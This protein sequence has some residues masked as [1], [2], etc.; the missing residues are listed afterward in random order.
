M[1][2]KTTHCLVRM[3]L[4]TFGGTF[5]SSSRR[6]IF[7]VNYS[8]F[9]GA[10]NNTTC[11]PSNHGKKIQIPETKLQKSNNRIWKY[12]NLFFHIFSSIK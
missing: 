5:D 2:E 12:H 3:A 11:G 7:V 8:L 10:F 4:W 9:W 1:D 6:T